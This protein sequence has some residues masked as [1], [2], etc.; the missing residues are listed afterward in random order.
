[1]GVHKSSSTAQTHQPAYKVLFYKLMALRIITSVKPLLFFAG[2]WWWLTKGEVSS[3][4]I[5]I[6]VVPFAAWLNIVLFNDTCLDKNRS[7]RSVNSSQSIRALRLFQFVPFFLVQSI[8]GGWRTAILSLRPS[9]PINPGFFR[10]QISLQGHSAQL[11]FMHLVSLL[12]GTLSA[13]ID[14]DQLLIHALEI[15]PLNSHDIN[16]CEQHVARLFNGVSGDD[17]SESPTH[18]DDLGDLS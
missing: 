12:P 4:V 17:S 18:T 10:Y 6:I 11:F 1:M 2:L 13:T 9:M 8:L 7:A 3:W 15:S 5:G 16:R 14:G